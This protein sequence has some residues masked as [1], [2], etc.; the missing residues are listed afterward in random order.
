MLLVPCFIADGVL[1]STFE[2]PLRVVPLAALGYG[3]WSRAYVTFTRQT[4]RVRR[5]VFV[6]SC[7]ASSLGGLAQL[8]LVGL[9]SA[10]GL[11]VILARLA[12]VFFIV[13]FVMSFAWMRLL[14]L[15][16]EASAHPS[17]LSVHRHTG[18]RGN[19]CQ[20]CRKSFRLPG[21]VVTLALTAQVV[22]LTCAAPFVTKGS[23]YA[24]FLAAVW[25]AEVARNIAY[26]AKACYLAFECMHSAPVFTR[27]VGCLWR[28]EVIRRC[29]SVPAARR[30]CLLSALTVLDIFVKTFVVMLSVCSHNSVLWKLADLLSP[31]TSRRHLALLA[32]K[33]ASFL[34]AVRTLRWFR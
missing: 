29:V 23:S 25:L 7:L 31:Y 15:Q 24:V 22:V 17:L 16:E 33:D 14:S 3:V 34:E 21:A 9:E 30:I 6:V 4:A 13:R 19:K 11:H 12:M 27:R 20:K 26:F 8:V 10:H 2:T 28:K 18:H 1:Y 5:I 32:Y